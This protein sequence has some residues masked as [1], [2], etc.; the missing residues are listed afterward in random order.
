MLAD[1]VL[2]V[3]VW[4]ALTTHIPRHHILMHI[5]ESVDALLTH[6]IYQRLDF[7]HVRAVIHARRAFDCLPHDTQS[8]QV[9]A[10]FFEVVD[11]PVGHGVLRVEF[12]RR[13]DVRVNLVHHI[14]SVEKDGPSSLVHNLSRGRVNVNLPSLGYTVCG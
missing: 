7:V 8:D 3:E 2:R 12:V 9:H 11:I 4:D 14:D 5:D 1:H 10:P 6:P 13:W